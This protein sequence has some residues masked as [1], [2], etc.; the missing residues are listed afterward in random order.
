MINIVKNNN[1]RQKLIIQE[2]KLRINESYNENGYDEIILA[3]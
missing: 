2:E 1:F 3:Y